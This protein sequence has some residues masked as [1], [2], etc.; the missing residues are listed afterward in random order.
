MKFQ[1]SIPAVGDSLCA[2]ASGSAHVNQTFANPHSEPSTSRSTECPTPQIELTL[3]LCILGHDVYER[4][5]PA[6]FFFFL[7][8]GGVGG[9]A[10]LP[11]HACLCGVGVTEVEIEAGD[12]VMEM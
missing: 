5:P 2:S 11:C 1:V 3:V 10:H 12:S 4:R 8:C 9:L 6:F 7:G